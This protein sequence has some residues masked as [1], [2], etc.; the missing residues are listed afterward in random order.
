MPNLTSPLVAAAT[1]DI[2]ELVGIIPTA[3]L[4]RLIAQRIQACVEAEFE[5]AVA[6]S[7]RI[8]G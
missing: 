3:V 1:A 8:R 5:A 7:E 4:A 2:C 6:E